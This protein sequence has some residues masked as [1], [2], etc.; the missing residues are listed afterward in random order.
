MKIIQTLFFTPPNENYKFESPKQMR[1]MNLIGMI[2][3]DHH[4]KENNWIRNPNKTQIFNTVLIL[5]KIDKIHTP[6][7][8]LWGILGDELMISSVFD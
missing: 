5:I 4:W 6:T 8:K 7:M 1:N 3:H 2:C